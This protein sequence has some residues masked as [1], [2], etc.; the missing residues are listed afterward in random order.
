MLTAAFQDHLDLQFL[1]RPFSRCR[2]PTAPSATSNM[3]CGKE[4]GRFFF[5]STLRLRKPNATTKGTQAPIG[6]TQC[7]L[8]NKESQNPT[9]CCKKFV[10]DQTSKGTASQKKLLS[11]QCGNASERQL[12]LPR[13]HSIKK[14]D[15]EVRDGAQVPERSVHPRRPF[16]NPGGFNHRG[17]ISFS[18]MITSSRS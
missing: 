6:E 8:R 4:T 9:L 7:V 12:S 3:G 16:Q 10:K 13:S 17:E 14:S 1:K 11:K 5:R 15:D 2:T 18:K